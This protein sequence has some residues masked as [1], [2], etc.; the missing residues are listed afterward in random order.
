MAAALF[1]PLLSVARD[2]RRSLHGLARVT[3]AFTF[4]GARV[5]EI[6]LAHPHFLLTLFT[7]I[8]SVFIFC[9]PT[10]IL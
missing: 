8:R 4:I 5:P 10:N 3:N 2:V 1:E 7:V 9:N 6:P